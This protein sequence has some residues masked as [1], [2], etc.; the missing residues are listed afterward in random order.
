MPATTGPSSC[1]PSCIS[2]RMPPVYFLLASAAV[3]TPWKSPKTPMKPRCEPGP[4]LA[5]KVPIRDKP[6]QDPNPQKTVLNWLCP[7]V[8]ADSFLHLAVTWR[9]PE[10]GG[11]PLDRAGLSEFKDICEGGLPALQ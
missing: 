3:T 6:T 8:L 10:K 5:P 4:K 11:I 2:G 1:M 7:K 9:A